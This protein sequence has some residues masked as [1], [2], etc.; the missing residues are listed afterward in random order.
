MATKKPM[1]TAVFRNRD[2]ALE[3][4]DFLL[5]RGYTNDEVNVLMSDRARATLPSQE[6]NEAGTMASEGMA[7]GGAI[8]T[9]VGAAAAAVAAIGTTVAGPIVA[10]LAGGGA[11]AVAGGLLGGLIGLG[12]PESNARAYEEALREGGVVIGVS[13]RTSQDADDIRRRFEQLH[14][15]NIISV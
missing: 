5:A 4:H 14:G 7:T 8:G 2:D 13:P 1:I 9:A 10:A 6:K 11:G 12:I 3:A 15:E